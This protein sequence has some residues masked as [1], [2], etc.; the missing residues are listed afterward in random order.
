MVPWVS[1][2]NCVPSQVWLPILKKKK[3]LKAIVI[4]KADKGD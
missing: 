2:H 1:S 3:K 4:V